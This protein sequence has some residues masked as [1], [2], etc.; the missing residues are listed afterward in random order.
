MIMNCVA[1]TAALFFI[2]VLCA[3]PIQQPSTDDVVFSPTSG[4]LVI[5]QSGSGS[6]LNTTFT[7]TNLNISNPDYDMPFDYPGLLDDT[8]DDITCKADP[9]GVNITRISCDDALDRMSLSTARLI[10]FG[11][12]G[13]GTFDINLPLRISSCKSCPVIARQASS[14]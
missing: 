4:S 1:L 7:D 11:Q 3:G 2:V 10:S 5:E 8:N 9:Y 12:R 6:I 14:L 13:R